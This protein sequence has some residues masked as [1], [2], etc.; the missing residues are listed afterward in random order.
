MMSTVA[1]LTLIQVAG[2][3]AGGLK[4][5]DGRLTYGIL[6]PTRAETEFLPGDRVVVSFTI[7][8]MTADAT[9]H[10]SYQSAM[11]LTDAKG[12]SVF[13][14]PARDN[15]AFNPLGGSSFPAFAAVDLGL[16]QAPGEYTLQVTV[17][18]KQGK[19]SVSQK[20]TVAQKGFGLVRI[21]ATCDH[22]GQVPAGAVS[23]GR[24]VWLQG[25]VVGFGRDRSTKQPNVAFEGRILDEGGKAT[26]VT[27][28][29]GVTKDVP[30]ADA[31]LPIHYLLPLNRSGKFMIEI[32]ATDR[33]T[34]KSVTQ[35][36][37]LNV[38]PAN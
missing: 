18:G 3:D 21:A 9:G 14:Q 2:A 13:K 17:S 8:G 26:T 10:V 5:S 30:D 15:K 37:P 36:Y 20:F 38:H 24:A 33:V 32:K 28:S 11:E 23:A 7:D 27:I 22:D 35:K 34:G 12:K 1:F 16:G 31:A 6:G 4:L 19:A 29:G 25:T